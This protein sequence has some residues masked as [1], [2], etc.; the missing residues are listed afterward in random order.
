MR[1]PA[2]I[3]LA[4]VLGLV[5]S[6]AI[7]DQYKMGGS[8]FAT[9][10]LDSLIVDADVNA[11]ANITATKLGT[12][13]VSNTELNLLD[14]KTTLVD[15]DDAVATAITATGTLA[16]V[17]TSGTITSSGVATDVACGAGETWTNSCTNA[18]FTTG[19]VTVPTL[20]TTV[21]EYSLYSARV[22]ATF[23]AGTSVLGGWMLPQAHTVTRMTSRATTSV[24]TGSAVFTASDGANTCTC[25]FACPLSATATTS[26]ACTNGAGTGCSY[27]AN[28]SVSV[29]Y[30]TGCTTTQPTFVGVAVYGLYN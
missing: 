28:A 14:G 2:V 23:S 29:T 8:G 25:T 10:I 16:S 3:V 13:A 20:A 11:A 19:K 12:G 17:T 7:A 15:T 9:A 5:A 6:V 26:Y 27:A 1:H 24:G 21:S 18:T 4:C 30:T 22:A